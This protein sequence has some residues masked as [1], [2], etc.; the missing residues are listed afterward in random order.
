MAF[1]Y[2]LA[3]QHGCFYV[4]TTDDPKRR[5][6]E[7]MRGVGSS[8][9]KRH[10]PLKNKPFLLLRRSV[11][12]PGLDEDRETK[13]WMLKRGVDRVR[14]GS[15]VGQRLTKDQRDVLEREMRHA[16][17]R[18]TTCGSGAHWAKQCPLA[19]T[20]G[21]AGAFRTAWTQGGRCV[22]TKATRGKGFKKTER[23]P[24]AC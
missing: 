20:R 18:C 9:T 15:F 11:G 7:H 12:T 24:L 2:V 21:R 22:S 1:V 14:G 23:N 10:P 16:G 19:K 6:A 17:Q 3:L 8:W 5:H 13:E 4:G